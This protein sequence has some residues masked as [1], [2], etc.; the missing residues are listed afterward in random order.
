MNTEKYSDAS[1]T[2]C[3]S[4]PSHTGSFGAMARPASVAHSENSRQDVMPC[5]TT[6]RALLCSR[7]PR[8]WA[9]CTEK[10]IVTIEHMP[11]KN[12]SDELMRPTEADGSAPKRPT[13]LASIYCMRMLDS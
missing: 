13:M 6:E 12:H 8:R 9:T 2:T 3:S 5:L 1:A 4:P 7:A 11:Q 10:P